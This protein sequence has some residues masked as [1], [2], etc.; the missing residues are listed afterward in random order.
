MLTL[1]RL[2]SVSPVHNSTLLPYAQHCVLCISIV[3]LE[4]IAGFMLVYIALLHVA[5][6]RSIYLYDSRRRVR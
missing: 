3:Y 4:T 6:L 1:K 5:Q 2:L